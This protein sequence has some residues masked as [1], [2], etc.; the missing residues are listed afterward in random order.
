MGANKHINIE[1]ITIDF[2]C[3]FF[4]NHV[5]VQF[6]WIFY[7][8]AIA[9]ISSKADQFEFPEIS[10]ITTRAVL[11]KKFVKKNRLKMTFKI[12]QSTVFRRALPSQ[13]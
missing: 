5:L 3:L 1:I 10:E 7:I 12:D 13:I 8:N 9:I 4:E 2:V 6:I 11:K